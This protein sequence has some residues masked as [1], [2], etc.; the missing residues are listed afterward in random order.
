MKSLRDDLAKVA[1]NLGRQTELKRNIDDNIQYRK[2]LEDEVNMT[3][4]IEG[5][6]EQLA[7]KGDLH[8]LEANLKRANTDSQRLL[9]EVSPV[10]RPES[11]RERENLSC[12][13]PWHYSAFFHCFVRTKVLQI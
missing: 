12:P 5:L 13:F 4:T 9:S 8:T 6:E 10:R 3:R 1:G 7:S 11:F 2:L